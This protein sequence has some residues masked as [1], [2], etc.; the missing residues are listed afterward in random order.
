[1]AGSYFAACYLGAPLTHGWSYP[2]VINDR[3]FFSLWLTNTSGTTMPAAPTDGVNTWELL[4]DSGVITD[5][6]GDDG[7]TS[8]RAILWTAVAQTTATLSVVTAD[9]TYGG[10]ATWYMTGIRPIGGR[11][12]AAITE[13]VE[14]AVSDVTAT[15][16]FD[17]LTPVETLYTD[18][19]LSYTDFATTDTALALLFVRTSMGT[20]NVHGS[21]TPWMNTYWSRGMPMF[22]N[23]WSDA[24]PVP[25]ND[26]EFIYFSGQ[27]KPNYSLAG[28]LLYIEETPLP[29]TTSERI[30]LV[31]R[32]VN[33][34]E[35]PYQVTSGMLDRELE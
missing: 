13:Q 20:Y 3:L 16:T 15:T 17:G 2:A 33:A 18:P 19:G 35:L 14:R 31:S 25:W 32:R 24:T 21:G 6:G 27:G 4:Y 7:W 9:I 30:E 29:P 5:S 11:R 23:G 10:G 8:G 1:M 22:I 26:P 28:V 12:P 34:R